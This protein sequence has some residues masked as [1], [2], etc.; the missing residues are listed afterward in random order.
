MKLAQITSGYY[1]HPDSSDPVRIEGDNPKLALLRERVVSAIEQGK[2][3]IVWARFRI[4]IEDIVRVLR[5]DEIAVVE[6][7]G[8]INKEGRTTAIEEFQ[9]G[10]ANV[11]VGQQQAGGTGIT[12]TAASCVIYFSNTFSLHDRLQTE[13]RAHRIGQEQDVTYINLVARN[14]IDATIVDALMNKKDIADI[15]TGDIKKLL[16]F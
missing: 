10:E 7:H 14:T 2:K 5:E 3:V 9:H 11:F 15:I 8:G 6:Y 12:L 4:E 1:I 13:D 16:P